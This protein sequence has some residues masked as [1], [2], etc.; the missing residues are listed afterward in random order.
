[1]KKIQPLGLL[2][3]LV[4]AVS[5]G[6]GDSTETTN[7]DSTTTISKTTDTSTDASS[8]NNPIIG[9]DTDTSMAAD[10]EFVMEAASGG[11]MEVALGKLAATNASSVQVKEFGQM[12]VADHTKAN[13]ELKAVAARKDVMISPSPIEKHQKHIDELKA[14]KGADFDKAYVKL[15]VED[16]KE[17]IEHFEDES[18]EGNDADV[19]AFATKT[20]PVLKKH[21]EHI[22][23][24][25]DGM[26]K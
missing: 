5:C 20:L 11:L 9:S 4:F 23:K 6:G 24:I 8:S 21:L 3:F 17:D 1:M 14:K 7:S 16:H 22:Q 2:V 25:Q 15:M 10:R 13:A 18:S 26:K 19:K 12:M